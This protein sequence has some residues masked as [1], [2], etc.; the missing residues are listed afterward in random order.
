[1]SIFVVWI[2]Q[3]PFSIDLNVMFRGLGL[4]DVVVSRPFSPKTYRFYNSVPGRKTTR[5]ERVS[6]APAGADTRWGMA[7][8]KVGRGADSTL[9]YPNTRSPIPH[10]RWPFIR[11]KLCETIG[12]RYDRLHCTVVICINARVALY[13][14]DNNSS[15]RGCIALGASPHLCDWYKLPSGEFSW[16][17]LNRGGWKAGT[18]RNNHRTTP[19]RLRTK[20]KIQHHHLSRFRL[21]HHYVI[22]FEAGLSARSA[23]FLI[24]KKRKILMNSAS[25]SKID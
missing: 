22:T 23:E 7:R 15:R 8:D 3:F 12:E 16:E 19:L 21:G 6:K 13:S 5:Y 10:N 25:A 17:E 4:V 20:I 1:M 9:E 11:R 24:R 2:N 14:I 18:T